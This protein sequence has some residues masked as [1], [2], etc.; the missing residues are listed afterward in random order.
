LLGTASTVCYVHVT[1]VSNG[2]IYFF[3]EQKYDLTNV[4]LCQLVWMIVR[5]L[6]QVIV[7]CEDIKK[8]SSSEVLTSL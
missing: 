1:A 7:K 6:T 8:K 2:S 3:T 4:S 5:A